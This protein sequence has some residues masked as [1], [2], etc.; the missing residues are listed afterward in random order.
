VSDNDFTALIGRLKRVQVEHCADLEVGVAAQIAGRT[1]WLRH[2][3]I[4]RFDAELHVTFPLV[5][6]KPVCWF[7]ELGDGSSG[8]VKGRVGPFQTVN[9]AV[10]AVEL[11]CVVMLEY[12]DAMIEGVLAHEFLHYV[13]LTKE[14]AAQAENGANKIDLGSDAYVKDYTHYRR[15]DANRAVHADKWLTSRLLDLMT[16]IEASESSLIR[17]AHARIA[18]NWIEPRLVPVERLDPTFSYDGTFVLDEEL[19]RQAIE[20]GGV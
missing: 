8:M 13:W 4:P 10:W 5:V 19:M 3:C 18:K 20:K 6:I 1:R 2:T 12:S 7:H 11:S 14:M 9:G 15:I 16:A 17:T